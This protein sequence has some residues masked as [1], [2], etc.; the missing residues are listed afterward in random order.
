MLNIS[1]Y[2][3]IVAVNQQSVQTYGLRIVFD[4]TGLKLSHAMMMMKRMYYLKVNQ[5][6]CLLC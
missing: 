5:Y 3:V 2:G 6:T 4:L 1:T